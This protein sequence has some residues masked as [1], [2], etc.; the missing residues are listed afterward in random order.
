MGSN[1]ESLT[2]TLD[3]AGRGEPAAAEQLLPLLYEELIALARS[4]MAKLP[5]GDTL[6][7]TA[8]VHEAYLRV[9]GDSDPGW[10]GRRHFFGAAARAMRNIVVDR[11]REKRAGKRGGGRRRVDRELEHLAPILIGAPA[12]D[13]IALD[14]ALS[15]LELEDERKA[16]VVTLRYFAGLS[17]PRIAEMLG[18]SLPT[19]ERDWRYAR[20]WLLREMEG[21]GPGGG[22]D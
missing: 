5:P 3:A 2:R 18:V 22:H 4:R 15:R 6:Q 9:V 14:E 16:Q 11:A 8:L 20:A 21:A 10:D 1:I 7:P 17:N 19:I 13:L 12:E